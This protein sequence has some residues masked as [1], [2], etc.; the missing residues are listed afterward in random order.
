MSYVDLNSNVRWT[1]ADHNEQ[2]EK[3]IRKDVTH[4]RE[5]V[6][7]RRMFQ[8]LL[9]LL[10]AMLPAAPTDGRPD[11]YAST[12]AALAGLVQHCVPVTPQ[13]F[14]EILAAAGVFTQG[15]VDAAQVRI[16]SARLDLALDY[17][18]ADAALAA[19][20]DRPYPPRVDYP[21][22][23]DGD[24]AYAQAC[25]DVD[26]TNAA[27]AEERTAARIAPQAVVDAATADTLDLVAWR[28][29]NRAGGI[30]A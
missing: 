12:R 6:V 8:M 5:H 29:A 13:Q 26:A 7:I 14:A 22:G 1:E 25:A 16:D 3:V 30:P 23:S 20:A 19:L 18:E 28:A 24:A 17:E 21:E 15:D 11:P 10:A 27:D 2:I 9:P 4:T